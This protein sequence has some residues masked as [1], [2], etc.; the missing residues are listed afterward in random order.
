[1]EHN[2]FLKWIIDD[3]Y[4]VS[5]ISCDPISISGVYNA[6]SVLKKYSKVAVHCNHG[7]NTPPPPS[8]NSQAKTLFF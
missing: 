7:D 2:G 5:A 4:L 6:T 8:L 1:M 3:L